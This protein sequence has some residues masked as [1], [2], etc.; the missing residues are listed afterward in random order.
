M[1]TQVDVGPVRE[2]NIFLTP[3]NEKTLFSSSRPTRFSWCPAHGGVIPSHAARGPP[4]RHRAFTHTGDFPQGDMR[5]CSSSRGQLVHLARERPKYGLSASRLPAHSRMVGVYP[6][7][8]SV[9]LSAVVVLPLRELTP[10]YGCAVVHSFASW[11]SVLVA[12]F[13]DGPREG[14]FRDGR[15]DGPLCHDD[16]P[17]PPVGR[18]VTYAPS[19]SHSAHAL[20]SVGPR[21]HEGLRRTRRQPLGVSV[22]WQPAAIVGHARQQRLPPDG[23]RKTGY[24]RRL[25]TVR[26][27]LSWL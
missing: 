5:P 2:P 12:S 19:S 4:P 7:A 21:S 3:Q 6:P 20:P 26:P 13:C 25:Q 14:V 22:S 1:M 17:R 16:A 23:E 24:P 15:G 10:Q 11:D 9:A 27:T 18:Y 8:P